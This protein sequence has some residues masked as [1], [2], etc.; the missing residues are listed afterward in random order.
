MNCILLISNKIDNASLL[1]QIEC[2]KIE[3]ELNIS[4]T[5]L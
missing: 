4:E 3:D 2:Q 5:A 1:S